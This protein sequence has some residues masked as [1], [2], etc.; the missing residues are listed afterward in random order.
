[1]SNDRYMLYCNY[2]VQTRNVV[3]YNKPDIVLIDKKQ[4]AAEIV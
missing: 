3:R 4:K 2:P 1:M